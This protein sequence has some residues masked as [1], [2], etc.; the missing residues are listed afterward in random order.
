MRVMGYGPDKFEEKEITQPEQIREFIGKFPVTWLNVDG[1][2]D[3]HVLAQLGEICG[4]HRLA[5]EDVINVRQRAKVEEYSHQT[6][7]VSRIV[8]LRERLETEQISFFLGDNF[9][10]TFQEDV[11]DCFDPVRQRIRNGHERMRVTGPDYLVYSLLD[12]VIDNYFPVLE[13]FGERIEALEQEVLAGAEKMVVSRMTEV[14][15]DLLTLRRAIWPQREAINS[16]LREPGSRFSEDTRLYLRDSYDHAVQIIDVLE[17]YRE[18]AG[19]LMDI[20]LSTISN[21]LNAVMK[22][23]TIIATIFMPLS[24]IASVYGMNFN[25]DS[26]LNMPELNWRYGYFF[27]LGLMATVAIGLLIYF[28]RKKWL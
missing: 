6:F 15:R 17:T 21:R 23:L 5:L 26:S 24:F 18:L 13:A 22:V 20:Y 2:G 14:K 11:G 27:S 19:G 16:L 8:T 12:S 4:L 1:L 7:L 9:V 3:A 28:R 25:T 10:I